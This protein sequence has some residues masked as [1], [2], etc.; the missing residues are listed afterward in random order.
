MKC[1]FCFQKVLSHKIFNNSGDKKDKSDF[2]PPQ[3]FVHC[4]FF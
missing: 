2:A 3:Y 1:F 4:E